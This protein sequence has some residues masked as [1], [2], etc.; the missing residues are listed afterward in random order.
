MTPFS[1]PTTLGIDIG[2]TKVAVAITNAETKEVVATASLPHESDVQGLVA[3]RSEQDVSRILSCLDA[4]IELLPEGT[5]RSATAIGTTGQMHGVVLWNQSNRDVS[6]LVT[7]QDQR[8]LEDGDCPGQWR[9]DR[10]DHE[11]RQYVRPGHRDPG[12]PDCQG[13]R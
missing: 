5:R 2:T 7:W 10:G 1:S 4:C 8:C 3:G 11:Q 9:T 13:H 12:R 6:H